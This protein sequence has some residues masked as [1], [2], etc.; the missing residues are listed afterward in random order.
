MKPKENWLDL[1]IIS[2]TVLL[3]VS[4][5]VSASRKKSQVDVPPVHE[6]PFD[7]T[8]LSNSYHYMHSE[9]KK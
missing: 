7:T 9:I 8:E 1:V 5:I 4:L 3:A 2:S 6:D